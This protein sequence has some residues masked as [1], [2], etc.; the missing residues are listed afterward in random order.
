MFSKCDLAPCGTEDPSPVRLAQGDM[1]GRLQ[2]FG[3]AL[4]S[5]IYF[6]STRPPAGYRFRLSL[7]QRHDFAHSLD[8]LFDVFI[9]VDG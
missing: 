7:D 6:R 9:G 5:Q 2:G 3:E 8:G 1:R 4:T